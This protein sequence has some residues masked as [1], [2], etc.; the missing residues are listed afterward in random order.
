MYVGHDSEI[1]QPGDYVLRSIGA[2]SVIMSR[3]SRGELHLF[4]NRCRHRANSVC[5]FEKGN[6]S[7]FRCAYHGWTYKNSGELVGLPFQEGAY[8]A[9]FRK[10]DFP[11]VEA[12]IGV[13]RGFIWGSLAPTG[14]SLDEHLGPTEIGRAHV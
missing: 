8:G 10:E 5:Q 12:R 3:D 13:Y 2:Q 14:I 11:L 9:D 7:F 1:P 4:M 6:S